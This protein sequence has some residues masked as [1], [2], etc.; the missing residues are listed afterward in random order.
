MQHRALACLDKMGQRLRGLPGTRVRVVGTN[1]VHS[2]QSGL[3]FGYVGLVEGLIARFRAEMG[4]EMKVIATG[5]LSGRI[6]AE[7]C[8][9]E[10]IGRTA[11]RASKCG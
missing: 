10:G 5:G 11:G 6:A 8:I 1:T 9:F 3:F 2:M 4:P 7:V